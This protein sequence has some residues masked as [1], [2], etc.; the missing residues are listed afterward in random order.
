[1]HFSFVKAEQYLANE[2]DQLCAIDPHNPF[3]LTFNERIST[4]NERISTIIP[5]QLS[6]WE[7][8]HGCSHSM[9]STPLAF[10]LSSFIWRGSGNYLLLTSYNRHL[11]DQLSLPPDMA[12]AFCV[13]FTTS[14]PY[15]HPR[16]SRTALCHAA[17]LL[18]TILS[19]SPLAKF[20]ILFHARKAPSLQALIT[21]TFSTLRCFAGVQ[22]LTSLFNLFVRDTGLPTILEICNH[23]PHTQT[24]KIRIRKHFLLPISL[25][26][27]T[28]K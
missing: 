16:N 18:T 12:R 9:H 6:K 10:S 22:Y 1:M 5:F 21:L 19:S 8:A 17:T 2:R 28:L 26:C 7:S 4:L 27:P 14:V 20:S 3:I 24:R 23:H 11:I 15:T 25:L 13:Q